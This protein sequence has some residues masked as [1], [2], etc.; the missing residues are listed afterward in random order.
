[1]AQAVAARKREKRNGMHSQRVQD[2]LA[3]AEEQGLLAGGRS[4]TIRGRMP[5]GLVAEAKKRTG[6]LSD[7]KLLEAALASIVV[8]DDYGKWL[9]SRRGTIPKD[10]DLEF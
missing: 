9:L 2:A 6:I 5:V 3:I 4:L 1:M 8:A 10:I 7:S